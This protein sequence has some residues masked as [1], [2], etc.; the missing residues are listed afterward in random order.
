MNELSIIKNLADWIDRQK[1][2]Y[3]MC[4]AFMYAWECDYWCMDKDGI[5]REFEIKISRS[6]FLIDAK[7]AKHTI[8][9][10]NYF[11]YVCP[12]GLI[13]KEEVPSK[14]GLIYINERGNAD[15]VKKPKK[16]HDKAFGQW[17]MLANKFH[18]RWW[19][20]W[21]DKYNGDKITKAEYVAGFL[22]DLTETEE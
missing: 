14:Y 20:L 11:Y 13:T 21:I 5:T 17:Q 19:Q 4:N 9:G 18:S 2:P 1:Y 7:K 8:Q 10:A 12:A 22:I 3:Q 6:D 16:L 15:V